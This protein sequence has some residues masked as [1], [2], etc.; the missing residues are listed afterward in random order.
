MHL[1]LVDI[2]D[3]L[4]VNLSSWYLTEPASFRERQAGCQRLCHNR[5][6]DGSVFSQ[7]LA[8]ATDT[9]NDTQHTSQA[10]LNAKFLGVLNGPGLQ[11]TQ[12]DLLTHAPI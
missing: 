7:T 4:A 10:V 1:G 11:T 8:A 6:P 9:S 12:V 2:I 3:D 5:Q